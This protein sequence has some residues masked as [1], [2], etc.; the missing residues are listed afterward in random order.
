MIDN[1]VLG[2]VHGTCAPSDDGSEGLKP[3]TC[4][5]QEG[6]RG[7]LCNVPA[8]EPIDTKTL[9]LPAAKKGAATKGILPNMCVNY[10]ILHLA[11]PAPSFLS[12]GF[13]NLLLHIIIQ[14][15]N[16]TFPCGNTQHL[17]Y[18]F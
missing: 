12:T 4:Q 13:Y 10:E 15:N 14:Y 3:W 2:C 11:T 17:N 8:A 7:M 1:F 6:W 16:T 18:A 5:C 9:N